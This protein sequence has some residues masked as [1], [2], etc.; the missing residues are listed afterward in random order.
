M[1]KVCNKQTAK[2]KHKAQL[3]MPEKQKILQKMMFV[4]ESL[5]SRI[6]RNEKKIR[7]NIEKCWRSITLSTLTFVTMMPSDI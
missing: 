4:K 1:C 2:N 7:K 3:Y 6:E 5:S